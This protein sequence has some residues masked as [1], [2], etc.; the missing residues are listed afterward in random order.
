MTI[1]N[2][3]L[4][5]PKNI[6]DWNDVEK[7]MMIGY[8]SLAIM[9]WDLL[10]LT[11]L[12]FLGNALNLSATNRI[13]DFGYQYCLTTSLLYGIMCVA[14]LLI[15][16]R[17]RHSNKTIKHAFMYVG[18]SVY[19]IGNIIVIHMFGELSTPSGIIMAGAPI[20]G[21]VLFETRA[22]VLAT[23]VGL[24]GIA[25]SFALTYFDITP[26]APIVDTQSSPYKNLSY[27]IAMLLF[28]V[29]H[30]AA[31]LF[32]SHS[33][34]TNW[35]KREEDASYLA[36][37]D[38]LTNIP[39]RRQIMQILQTTIAESLHKNTHTSVA[40]FDLDNFKSIND[41]YG[42]HAGDHVLNESVK[43][44][45]KKLRPQDHIGRLGG[46]EFFIILPDCNQKNAV[47]AMKR[48]LQALRST[49]IFI[50]D[51]KHNV[52]ASFGVLVLPDTLDDPTAINDLIENSFIDVDTALYQA[53]DNGRNQVFAASAF[54]Y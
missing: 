44:I 36:G 32:L 35:K 22:V 41:K 50:D 52:T 54:N 5:N 46:D 3:K 28:I 45:K 8:L 2:W 37:I 53:K 24:I 39:N 31:L 40:M 19:A 14:S 34:I 10:S 16:S 49:D 6:L 18:M 42:H 17:I 48:C 9:L 30:L 15:G 21:W 51:V 12:Y 25:C 38:S 20:V 33:A 13:S 27:I 11:V 43:T 1:Q 26:Y 4:R 23:F 29:P 7:G 47:L